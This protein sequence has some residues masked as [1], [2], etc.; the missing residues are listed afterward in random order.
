MDV[1]EH[2]LGRVSIVDLFLIADVLP[3]IL[4]SNADCFEFPE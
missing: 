1:Q 2:D 4:T 3:I